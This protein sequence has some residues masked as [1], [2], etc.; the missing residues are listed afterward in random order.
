[1]AD[2]LF[3]PILPTYRY[4]NTKEVVELVRGLPTGKPLA[5]YV[6]S[7]NDKVTQEILTKTS[8]GGVCVNDTL[9]HL[10]N[11]ELPF[12]GVGNSGLGSYHG[13]RTFKSFSHEKAVLTKYPWIDENPLV[14]PLLDMRFPPY[15]GV[16]PKI[17]KLLANPKVEKIS[18]FLNYQLPFYIKLY[19]AWK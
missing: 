5:L 13:H 17:L 8:S 7:Q 18:H 16:K 4:S 3:G 14:K 11:H 6:F 1:M 15:D 9:M 10:G 2:E 19:I 12:G